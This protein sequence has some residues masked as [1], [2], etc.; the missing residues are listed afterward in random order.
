[1]KTCLNVNVILRVNC[2]NIYS[3]SAPVSRSLSDASAVW[4][5]SS[6]CENYVLSAPWPRHRFYV[7]GHHYH[8]QHLQPSKGKRCWEARVWFSYADPN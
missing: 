1:M 5:L 4:V 2:K 6:L 3:C 7:Q 8:V